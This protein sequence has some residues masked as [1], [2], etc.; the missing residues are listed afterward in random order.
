MPT[1]IDFIAL[2]WVLEI[3]IPEFIKLSML[4]FFFFYWVPSRV[5]P[6]IGMDDFQDKIMFNILY[7]LVYIETVIPLMFVA[8]IY[9]FPLF[10]LTILITKILVMKFYDKVPLRLYF[11]Q[12]QNKYMVFILDVLDDLPLYIQKT[13]EGVIN[14]IKEKKRTFSWIAAL[15]V[16]AITFIFLYPN[17]LITLRGFF[18][19]TYGASDTA[20]FFEWVSF[21]YRGE[22]F[23]EGKT[24]GADFYG[25]TVLAFFISNLSNAPLHVIFSLYPFFTVWFLLFGLFYFVKKMTDSVPTGVFAVFMFGTVLMTPM[26]DFFAGRSY[27]TTDPTVTN[28]F[29]FD[30]FL[31]WPPNPDKL[32]S[33][34]VG[35][36]P[37]TRNSCGLPYEL[38]YMFLLPNLYFFI[39]SFASEERKYLWWYG[40][41]LMLVFTFHGGIAFYLVA[42]S[43]PIAVWAIINGKLSKAKLGWGLVAV[44]VGAVVG[45]AWLLSIFKYGG[46]GP[47]GA[48]A[49]IIDATLQRLGIIQKSAEQADVFVANADFDFEEMRI[50]LPSYSL[51]AFVGAVILFFILS[52]FMRRRFEWSSSALI[53][54]G[55]LFIFGAT[56]FGV[57]QLV[58]ATRAA[59]ALLLSWAMIGSYYFYMLIIHPL[60]RFGRYPIARALF[61][62]TALILAG[63]IALVTP[64]WV[65]TDHF[66]KE[67]NNIEYS[68]FGYSAYKIKQ[69]YQPFTWTIISYNPEYAEVLTKGYHYNTHDFINE[70]DPTDKFLRVPTPKVFLFL[71]N[72]PHTYKGMGEW[73]YRWRETVQ[74]NYQQ[75]ILTYQLYHPGKLKTW[76]HS[77]HAT[78]YMIDNQDYMDELFEQEKRKNKIDMKESYLHEN[79]LADERNRT[80]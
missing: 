20:Q 13:K 57:P 27:T 7:M 4:M 29:G 64:R 10:L 15:Q 63:T 43:I 40:V 12:M 67:L 6:Q 50:L 28:F 77:D 80:D 25:M 33:G 58:D 66:W 26:I 16:T 54:V 71:E 78:V 34:S 51:L 79:N 70:F 73:Y 52:Q 14:T 30:L 19:F 2:P 42:A 59:E 74:E 53:A 61:S 21:L 44:V 35:M 47:I 68:D 1:Y 22:L 72:R 9:S 45:N 5:F 31:P 56:I 3:L 17:F 75:W 32:P 76:Y 24:F 48:A 38:G 55:V 36:T 65:E 49:P 41:T 18:T 60:E 37:Y 8:G 69:D 23:Y 62:L 11:V 39:K 46:L